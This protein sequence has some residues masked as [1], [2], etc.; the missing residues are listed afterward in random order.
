[1]T[2]NYDFQEHAPSYVLYNLYKTIMLSALLLLSMGVFAQQS[3]F[4]TILEVGGNL[5]TPLKVQTDHGT[6]TLYSSLTLDGAVSVRS[7]TDANGNRVV[8]PQGSTK[9][10][11]VTK[12]DKHYSESV[13][14]YHFGMIYNSSTSSSSSSSSSSSY[15][16]SSSSSSSNESVADHFGRAATSVMHYETDG[17]PNV[18]VKLGW[19]WLMGENVQLKTCLGG[20]GGFVLYGGVGSEFAYGKNLN[21]NVGVGYYLNVDADGYSDL[22]LGFA[23]GKSCHYDGYVFT[24]NLSYTYF[25]DWAEKWFGVFAGA[26]LGLAL[27]GDLKFVWNVEVGVAVKLWQL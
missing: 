25:F 12:G 18:N 9:T 11:A 26:D 5:A 23:F 15:N 1:M 17:Y 19:S 3:T 21:W 14:T 8:V 20:M 7:A 24:G 4:K 13:R 16:S 10:H 2:N 22:D 6:Y 27:G